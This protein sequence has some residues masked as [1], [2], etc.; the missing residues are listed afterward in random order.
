MFERISFRDYLIKEFIYLSIGH[1][2]DGNFDS[3]ILKKD[4]NNITL[5]SKLKKDPEFFHDENSGR[6]LDFKGRIDHDKS[7]ISITQEHGDKERLDYL[8]S[9]LKADYP[10]YG[11]WYFGWGSPKK[12]A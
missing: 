4:S 7:L 5:A 6:L 11:I 9:I 8:V 10:D 1:N 2:L 3:W 12:L